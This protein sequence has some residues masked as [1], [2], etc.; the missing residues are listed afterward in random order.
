MREDK[1]HHLT[2]RL[3]FFAAAILSWKGATSLWSSGTVPTHT[4]S[5][6]LMMFGYL[7]GFMLLLLSTLRTPPKWAEAA[8]PGAMGLVIFGYGWIH[9]LNESFSGHPHTTDARIYM[10]YAGRLLLRGENPY[11]HDLVE[12]FR[13]FR[14]PMV[15]LTSL[16]DGDL[17][18]RVA[19]PAGS[20]LLVV[21]FLWLGVPSDL[22]Y[23]LFFVA[24]LAVLYFGV[25]PSVRP[26]ILVPFIAEQEFIHYC[27]GGVTDPVWMFFLVMMIRDWPRLGRR[28][29]WYGLAAAYK[30]Q[31]WVMIP[32]LLIRI[33]CE[34]QGE[35]RLKMVGISRF[36]AISSAVFLAI[37]VPFIIWD[38]AAWF[39]GVT[40]PVR[41]S[42]I[43]FGEGLSTLTMTGAIV[44]PK[45]AYTA[46]MLGVLGLC[47][48]VYARH[49]SHLR[50][51]LWIAPALALWFA[52]R[53]L[54]SYWYFN[55]LPLAYALFRNRSLVDLPLLSTSRLRLT[56]VPVF[57]VLAG[58]VAT[59]TWYGTR[60]PVLRPQIQY[61]ILTEGAGGSLIKL[62]VENLTDQ[63]IE[64]RFTVQSVALQ[65]MFW[66]IMS[67][68]RILGP[69]QTRLFEITRPASFA[70]WDISRG[71]RL[72]VADAHRSH[73]RATIP[74][75]A[76]RDHR[77]PD[78]IPNGQL[79]FWERYS[80]H[81]TFWGAHRGQSGKIDI[82]LVT[83]MEPR[84]PETALRIKTSRTTRL[85]DPPLRAGIDTYVMLPTQPVHIRIFLPQGA[86]R[87][88]SPSLIYGLRLQSRRDEGW[89]LFGD[90]PGITTIDNGY[91]K[92]VPCTIIASPRGQWSE[93]VIDLR[94]VLRSF[95]F[96]IY[97]T[98]QEI[99][100]FAHID[101][102]SM[103]LSIHLGV[104]AYS[105]YTDLDIRFGP[106][107]NTVFETQTDVLFEQGRHHPEW[108]ETWRGNYNFTARNYEK[109]RHHFETAIAMAPAYGPAHMGLAETLF[110]LGDF[111]QAG[112][113]YARTVKMGHDPGFAQKGVGW[114]LY[115]L[116]QYR[117]A[118]E[119]WRSALVIFSEQVSPP[120]AH[121][122]DTLKG[123][124]MAHAQ[125]YQCAGALD[126]FFNA[127]LTFK[128]IEL[129]FSALTQC[130][131]H[132]I[133]ALKSQIA[134]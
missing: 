68:P 39:Y 52:N 46:M 27:F 133:D 16:V 38:P 4:I 67:G 32:F 116:R 62:W 21:P 86:N 59:V 114:S 8:I 9:H 29:I 48:W 118:I 79:R 123:L 107:T 128:G 24:A 56:L 131:Q 112:Q 17:S 77:R 40:E 12:S 14:E 22:I 47:C 45:V 36:I 121:V 106:L 23:P 64:P 35:T 3:G 90:Q 1:L 119:A 124:A 76:S 87:F 93:H 63:E 109:A 122:E 120:L 75:P 78:A 82:D 13:I 33:Y 25:R 132:R 53:S 96:Q 11:T 70:G 84:G 34:T 88:P 99:P 102:P 89:I 28:A 104:L 72:T 20:V 19:Y 65:P 49:I 73:I 117:A 129:P 42:M 92:E 134:Q 111:E 85:G 91:G 51:F 60:T 108:M 110:W 7:L 5:A 74:I 43:T 58:I 57:V 103:P 2:L 115:N 98:R 101:I 15:F 126:D 10:D 130:S 41:A 83:P 18:G 44:I 66:S 127:A 37:N 81:P 71:A 69:G 105:P 31:P 61:P 100:R 97:E 30:H 26:L 50:E 54:T 55:A 113:A 80:D 94:H 125:T 6:N 95:N